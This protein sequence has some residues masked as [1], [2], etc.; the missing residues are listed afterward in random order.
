MVVEI[1]VEGGGQ[2]KELKSQCREGFRNFFEK[3]GIESRMLRIIACGPR[4]KAYDFFRKAIGK[5]EN[6]KLLLLLVDSE[7]PVDDSASPWAHLKSR[8]DDGW[9]KPPNADENSVHLMVQ[10]MESWF[11][12]DKEAL[13]KFYGQGF[14]GKSLPANPNIERIPKQ[15]ISKSLKRAT[16]K[17]IR[18]G[19][20]KGRDSFKILALIDPTKV[21]A[22]SSH[23]GRLFD[24]LASRSA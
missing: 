6:H 23:A 3:A 12:A 9:D 1:Y 18:G 14:A 19:Y 21:R 16:A 5:A 22:A 8:E 13:A 20:D 2:A 24:T 7:A 15:D 11:L 10:C 4:R 17:T